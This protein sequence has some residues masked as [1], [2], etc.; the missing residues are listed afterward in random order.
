MILEHP[1][2]RFA[3][4]P[5]HSKRDIPIGTLRGILANAGIDVDELRRLL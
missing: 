5:V 4:V 2:G 1:D 3:S